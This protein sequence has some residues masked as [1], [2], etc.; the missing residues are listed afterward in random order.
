MDIQIPFKNIDTIE[1]DNNK[2]N[3]ELNGWHDMGVEEL[4]GR[5]LNLSD[6]K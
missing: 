1:E 4:L 5:H 3:K 6:T 2:T